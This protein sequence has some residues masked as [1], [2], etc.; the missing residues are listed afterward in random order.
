[1]A[2]ALYGVAV[3]VAPAVGPAL[4]GWITDH[5][6]WRWIFFIN[7]PVGILSL[8]MTSILVT[9]SAA[10]RKEHKKATQGGIKVDYIGFA[11]IRDRP[12]IIAGGIGQG[13][14]KTD[15]FGSPVIV[16]F[17]HSQRLP[18]VLGGFLGTMRGGRTHCGPASVSRSGDFYLREKLRRC[19]RPSLCCNPPRSLLPQFVQP[20]Y[21]S[22]RC[23]QGGA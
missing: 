17:G 10:A 8:V 23:H 20:R 22:L 4:G 18:G 3:V 19:F 14:R 16:I 11:L 7:V 12:R 9:D 6:S 21:C 15:W 1:M 2:F 5:Y 13:A